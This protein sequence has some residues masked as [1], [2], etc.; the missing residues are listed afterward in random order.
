MQQACMTASAGPLQPVEHPSCRCARTRCWA[1]GQ[2]VSWLPMTIS[3]HRHLQLRTFSSPTGTSAPHSPHVCRP[4]VLLTRLIWQA[5]C[6]ELCIP[7]KHLSLNGARTFSGCLF[8]KRCSRHISEKA[9][10]LPCPNNACTVLSLNAAI[11]PAG[12]YAGSGAI[13]TL[14]SAAIPPRASQA[15]SMCS[16]LA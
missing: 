14:I 1:N 6:H 3:Q 15:P 8:V 9:P 16:R 2:S 13:R 12:S 4:H 5:W 7:A 11:E 10:G